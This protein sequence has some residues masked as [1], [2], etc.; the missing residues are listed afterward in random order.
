METGM[1]VSPGAVVAVRHGRAEQLLAAPRTP[2]VAQLSA[3]ARPGHTCWHTP[4]AIRISTHMRGEKQR[5]PLD[6]KSNIGKLG[7]PQRR[8]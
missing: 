6:L 3:G 5:R 2:A 7:E 8:G 1:R 4:L